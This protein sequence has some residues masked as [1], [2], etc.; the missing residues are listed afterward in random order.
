MENIYHGRRVKGPLPIDNPAL[1]WRCWLVVADGQWIKAE[2]DSPRGAL[3][4]IYRQIDELRA[5]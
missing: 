5:R 3:Q 2:S 4:E 1:P